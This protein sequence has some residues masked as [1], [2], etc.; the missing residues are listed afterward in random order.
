M[1]GLVWDGAATKLE[2]FF[3]SLINTVALVLL[4]LE[5]SEGHIK[6]ANKVSSEK[7]CIK[8]EIGHN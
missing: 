8:R 7:G 2:K 1:K 4:D 5:K 6:T 3:V